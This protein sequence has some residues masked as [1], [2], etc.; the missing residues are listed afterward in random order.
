MEPSAMGAGPM[1]AMKTSNAALP[2]EKPWKTGQQ[3]K[4][5]TSTH[6]DEC[7][8]GQ[9]RYGCCGAISGGPDG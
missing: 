8:V 4:I 6:E 1:R 9:P 7:R 3:V 5:S 2:A